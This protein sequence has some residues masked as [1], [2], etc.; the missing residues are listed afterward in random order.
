MLFLTTC[1]RFCGD[2]SPP[3]DYAW[4]LAQATQA[5]RV[6]DEQLAK[7]PSEF[8]QA[9]CTNV[10]VSREILAASQEHGAE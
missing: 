1:C 8:H 2:Y 10:H 7:V 6:L 5:K 3:T 9:M 4:Y